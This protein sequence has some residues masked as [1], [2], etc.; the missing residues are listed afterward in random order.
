M[1]D[2][3]AI[4]TAVA[5]QFAGRV[6]NV[7][8]NAAAA[9]M[10]SIGHQTGLFDTLQKLPASTSS[11]FAVAAGLNER[12]VREWLDAMTVARFVEYDPGSRTY[13]LPPEHAASLTRDAGPANLAVMTPFIA[14][15]AEVEQP[16]IDCFRDG[17]GLPYSAYERFHDIMAAN[18]A[19]AVD[20]ALVDVV[21]P[22]VSGLPDRLRDG[23]DVLDIGCGRGHAVNV[24]AR[25]FPNSRFTGYDFSAEAIENARREVVDW[26]LTNARFDIVDVARL[27]EAAQYDFV[28]A[29]DA[30]HDQAEPTE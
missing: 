5:E 29:F 22:L 1:T 21:L 28:T 2:T 7:I 18:S 26:E 24:M 12:Y 15:L 23:I 19:G 6:L 10:T 4:D 17:G 16:I 13:T 14:M 3:V 20:A 9:L 27:D 8:D 11:E 25:A 30:I